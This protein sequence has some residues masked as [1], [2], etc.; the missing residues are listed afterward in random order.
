MRRVP[1]VL[2]PALLAASLAPAQDAAARRFDTGG[3]LDKITWTRPF[4][5]AQQLARAGKRVMLVKPILGG[6][7]APRPDG[8]PCG[9]K[10]DC[11]G[12]W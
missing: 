5:A 2:F 3:D 10:N 11:E 8:V 9:G 7:N 12:S 6:G 1:L 4:A